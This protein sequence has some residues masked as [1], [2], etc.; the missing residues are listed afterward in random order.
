MFRGFT[1]KDYDVIIRA[2][3][4]IGK[5]LAPWIYRI[6]F[7]LIFTFSIFLCLLMEGVIKIGY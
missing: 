4:I 7:I 5:Y 6:S 3:R 2:I 1:T